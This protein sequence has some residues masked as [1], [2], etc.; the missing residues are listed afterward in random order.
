LSAARIAGQILQVEPAEF[1]AGVDMLM[2]K[3]K[4]ADQPHDFLDIE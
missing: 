3:I 1:A 4:L 2:S